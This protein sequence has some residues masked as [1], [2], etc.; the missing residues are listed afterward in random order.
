MK[1]GIHLRHTVARILVVVAILFFQSCSYASEKEDFA[2]AKQQNTLEAWDA[3][4]TKHPKGQHVSSAKEAFDNLLFQ[5]ATASSSDAQALETIFKRCKTPAVADKVFEMWDDATWNKAKGLD[6][7]SA[8]RDYL[9]RFPGGVHVGDAKTNIEGV[10]W[11][12]CRQNGKP[13]SYKQYLKEYPNG[14]HSKE[15]QET[16]DNLAYQQAKEKDTVEAYEQYLK[17]Y[18]RGKHAKEARKTLDGLAYQRAKEKD[19]VEA[20]EQYLKKYSRGKHAKEARKTLDSLAYQ[21]AKEKDTVEAYEKFLKNRYG[22]EA[23]EKRLRQLRYERAV[24]TGTLQDWLAFYDKYRHKRWKGDGKDVE[25]MKENA[26]KEIERLLYDKIFAS[27]SLETCKDY[28]KRY[29]KGP[30]KQQVIVKMEPYLYEYS[31][32]KNSIDI[33]KEYLNTYPKGSQVDDVKKRLDPILFKKAQQD[34]WYSSYEEYIKECPYGINVQKARDRIV[35]LKANKAIVEVVY[36]K[37]LEQRTS[38]YS[39]VSSPFWGWDTVFKEKSGKVGFKVRGSGYIR[40]PQGR[41]WGSYGGRIS[42]GEIKVPA[43]GTGKDD[44]WCS[45]S[46][47]VFCNGY[48]LFTWTGEDAGGHPISID[49]KVKLQHTGCPGPKKK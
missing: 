23:A 12:T 20:Y 33:Y 2:A 37:V 4:L 18:S 46:D 17:K 32:S 9:L 8:Y 31:L 49:V 43:G 7:A 41:R 38:P 26:S 13:E 40:D 15:A 11:R 45:S 19:T 27:P 29:P 10:L 14:K 39:N 48:A 21:R 35:W 34:D 22:H 6:S 24:E 36:P 25:Q 28:L 1:F 44:Y 3:F 30:H 5:Q 47:H 16:L 42:R